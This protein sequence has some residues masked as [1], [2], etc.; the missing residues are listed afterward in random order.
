MRSSARWWFTPVIPKGEIILR[1]IPT[2]VHTLED[3]NY[4]L[5]AFKAVKDKLESGVYASME[6]PCAPTRASHCGR[7]CREASADRFP[8]GNRSFFGCVR[9]RRP[10]TSE[11][12]RAA[13]PAARCRF[14]R[15]FRGLR[16]RLVASYL[17]CERCFYPRNFVHLHD[18]SGASLRLRRTEN[19][20][21]LKYNLYVGIHLSGA[22]PVGRTKRSIVC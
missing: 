14:V 15:A 7:R 9:D 1:V 8:K 10:A 18:G 19:R 21:I 13:G 11:A 17:S 16:P 2:A 5:E 6:I 12:A 3:V 20:T 22:V 4:T